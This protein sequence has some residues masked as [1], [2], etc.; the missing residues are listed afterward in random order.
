MKY[1]NEEFIIDTETQFKNCDIF[2]QKNIPKI[3]MTFNNDHD[4]LLE[5]INLLCDKIGD[6]IEKNDDIN[7]SH[8]INPI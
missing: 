2:I 3:K 5:T 7:I 4:K 6:F 1:K 8:I